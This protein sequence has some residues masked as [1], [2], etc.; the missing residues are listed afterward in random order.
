LASIEGKTC[1]I[2]G[3]TS[4][5]GLTTARALAAL[6]VRLVLV[7]RD[8]ARGDA[9]LADLR[10]RAPRLQAEI[11]YAD[12]SHL[13]EARRLGAELSAA[14]PRI[15]ILINNAGALFQRRS[16]TTDGLERTFELNHMAY[17]VLT[18]ALRQRLIAS[19]P[20]RI[21]NVASEAH[22]GAKLDF[23]DLQL[24]RNYRGLT[25][26]NRSK[27]CNILFTRELARRLAGSGVTA[28]CLHPGFVA[29]RFGDE[30]GGLFR[31]GLSLAKRLFAISPEQGA[32]T[33]V[34]VATSPESEGITGKYFD[35]CAPATPSP[36]AADDAAARRLWEESARL[37]NLPAAA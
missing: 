17:F 20:A 10:A 3:A 33:S 2:T 11:H 27:L 18:E 24:E 32:L 30:N 9:A 19:A 5:I 22:R 35:K 26:Y 12:L 36:A 8:R 4:G 21:V 25:A 14:L 37:A 34:Y 16:V 23:D 7:G 28:N 31:V 15:D 13:D 29:T 1:V 6:G